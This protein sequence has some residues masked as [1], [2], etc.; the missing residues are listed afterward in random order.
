MQRRSQEILK[1]SAVIRQATDCL[2]WKVLYLGRLCTIPFP[3]LF[4][5]C[6]PTPAK[7]FGNKPGGR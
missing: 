1:P 6:L 5:K 4:P 2:P 7:K 3:G